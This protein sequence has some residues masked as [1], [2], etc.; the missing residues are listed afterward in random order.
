MLLDR[1]SPKQNSGS[2]FSYGP[3]SQ[4]FPPFHSALKNLCHSFGLHFTSCF[5]VFTSIDCEPFWNY[6][7][8][9]AM[10]DL[11][12]VGMFPSQ[13]RPLCSASFPSPLRAVGY[14]ELILA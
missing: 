8:F 12:D 2:A 9:S 14:Y 13:N 4:T 3:L 7:L 5:R 6:S 10:A 1:Y 11:N